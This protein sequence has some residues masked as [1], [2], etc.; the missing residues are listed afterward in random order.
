MLSPGVRTVIPTE[1]GWVTS[2]AGM[3]AV[4]RVELTKVVG[5]ASPFQK[6]VLPGV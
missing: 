1:V 5:L 2:S 3:A 4:S 6:T